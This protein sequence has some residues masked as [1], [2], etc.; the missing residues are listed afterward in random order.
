MPL[1]EVFKLQTVRALT[2]WI[3]EAGTSAYE[4]I[5]PVEPM[6]GY[7]LSYNQKRLWMLQQTNP[8]DTTFNMPG[9]FLLAEEVDVELFKKCLHMVAQ[10]HEAFRTSFRLDEEKN[11][12]LQDI[13]ETVEIPL[14]VEDLCHLDEDGQWARR[15]ELA[16][17]ERTTPFD[18]TRPPLFRARLLKLAPNRWEF[19][20]NMHHIVSDGWSQEVLKKDFTRYYEALAS[21]LT[22]PSQPLPL[23]YKDFAAWN[24]SQIQ[25]PQLKE[26]AESF[27]LNRLEQGVPDFH[28]LYDGGGSEKE[29]GG[30]TYRI[31]VDNEVKDGL[32]K[33]AADSRTT[34]FVLMFSIFNWIL[35]RFSGSK[36]VVCSIISAGRDHQSLQDIVGYFINSLLSVQSV[37]FQEDFHDF[38]A[39]MDADIMELFQVQGYPLELLLTEMKRLHP[40]VTVSFNML[41]IL[42]DAAAAEAT[43]IEPTH[44]QERGDV[45][46]NLA[47]HAVE[48]KNALEMRWIYKKSLFKP[49]TIEFIATEYIRLLEAVALS[50]EEDE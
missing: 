30:V 9:G 44:L 45:K 50:E 10:R 42:D 48:Y 23:Q 32:K 16:R 19:L 26:R 5:E 11:E 31:A 37:D 2:K 40:N 43:T 33:M 17:L 12:P 35:A 47:L 8:G 3:S 25:D 39:R 49:Q 22:V 15:K 36:E 7:P 38:L 6:D 46:F 27:W 20:Y 24:N 1:T 13:A 41:N 4:S 18:L 29:T 28:L 21:G 34:L 14:D